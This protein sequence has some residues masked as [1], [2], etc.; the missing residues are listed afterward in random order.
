MQSFEERQ[1]P[2]SPYNVSK[3]S[4]VKSLSIQHE[5]TSY[6]ISN[7]VRQ[8]CLSA[9]LALAVT[10]LDLQDL[11]HPQ[12]FSDKILTSRRSAYEFYKDRADLFFAISSFTK[13]SMVE[14]LG[15]E[16]DKIVVTYLAADDLSPLEQSA[17]AK[18]WCRQFGRF[19][20]YPAKMW[21]H[22]NHEFLLRVLGRRAA[23][24]KNEKIT[25]V[26]TGGFDEQDRAHLLKLITE[27]NLNDIVEITGF[28]TDSQLQALM[29]SAEFLFFPSLFEGFGMP[30]LEAMKRGC[31]V[32]VSKVG[33]L[34][35]ICGD[36]AVYFDPAQEDELISVVDLILNNGGIQREE[37]IQKGY[38][39]CQR[40]S[41]EKTFD[42]TV[43]AYSD[44]FG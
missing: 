18:K 9:N 32:V 13:S 20:L 37:M 29:E 28:V 15:I 7:E 8:R 39:N 1:V 24:L 21:R 14:K 23:E 5:L 31:P 25:M 17:K 35:E 38:Q 41:W 44:V 10:F 11:Y 43:S 12:Y 33:P 6:S 3:S 2:D 30:V 40:F 26:L 16:P 22:K 42:K 34:P 36:A 4:A 19:W 27:A